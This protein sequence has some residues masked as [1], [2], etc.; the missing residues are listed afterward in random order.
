MSEVYGSSIT[1]IFKQLLGIIDKGLD[2]LSKYGIRVQ[3]KEVQETTDGKQKIRYTVYMGNDDD[4]VYVQI[5]HDEATNKCVV[6]IVDKKGNRMKQE[7]VKPNSVDEVIRKFGIKYYNTDSFI[8]ESKRFSVTL[9]KVLGSN[10]TS[11]ELINVCCGAL[12]GNEVYDIVDSVLDSPEFNSMISDEPKSF[13][14]VDT[15]DDYEI[16]EIK[17]LPDSSTTIH[18]AILDILRSAYEIWNVANVCKYGAYGTNLS[19]LNGIAD[20]IRYSIHYQI[21]TLYE[22][23]VQNSSIMSPFEIIQGLP[24]ISIGEVSFTDGCQMLTDG[25]KEYVGKL[26]CYYFLIPFEYQSVVDDWLRTWN[27]EISN[28]ER[29]V[30]L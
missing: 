29:T 24:N 18:D 14:F 1:D 4:E 8:Q 28:L 6:E 19:T 27:R 16:N 30:M 10:Y 2:E 5:I 20:N 25:L 9:K 22:L 12:P 11:I 15:G 13:E 21:D 3:N 26:N 7:N 17:L 23:W